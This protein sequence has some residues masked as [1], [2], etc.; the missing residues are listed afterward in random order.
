[1]SKSTA[2]DRADSNTPTH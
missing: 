1:M 2:S